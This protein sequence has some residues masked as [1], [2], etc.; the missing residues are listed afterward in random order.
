MNTTEQKTILIAD[1]ELAV[2]ALLKKTLGTAY[3]VLEASD[4]EEAVDIACREKPDLIL[5]DIMMPRLDG[6]GACS[7]IKAD[8]DNRDIPVIMV[9]AR[10]QTPD[11]EYARE[12]GANGYIV[13]PFRPKQLL[14]TVS[15]HLKVKDKV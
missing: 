15:N 10:W 2:R 14:E 7:I 4:G 8:P 6:I 3:T 5:L 12:M 13:K 1:D 9:T 11:Q